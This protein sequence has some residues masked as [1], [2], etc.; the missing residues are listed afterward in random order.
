MPR[1]AEQRLDLRTLDDLAA[2]HDHRASACLSDDA[3]VSIE[4]DPRVT[5]AAHVE[6]LARIGFNRISMGVQD[7]DPKV[8][9]TI[10]RV[11]SF[12]QTEAIVSRARELGFVSV[13]VDLIY[14]LPY[15]TTEGFQRTLDAVHEL[16]PDRIACYSYAHVPWVRPN[17]EKVDTTIM[18][19]GYDKFQLFMLTVDR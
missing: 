13:N 15:Q 4:V 17:Q 6:T 9:K 3:E 19:E 1:A 12:A 14:G 8:Q 10:N 2:V 5:T 18:L 16:S 7:F 11:Q